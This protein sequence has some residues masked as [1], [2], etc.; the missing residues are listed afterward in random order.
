MNDVSG[1]IPSVYSECMSS[2]R[3]L[4]QTEEFIDDMDQHNTHTNINVSTNPCLCLS[5]Y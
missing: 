4:F 3:S 1:F 2:L 5:P